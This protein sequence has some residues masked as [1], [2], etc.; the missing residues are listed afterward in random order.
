M[1]LYLRLGSYLLLAV[2]AFG[3]GWKV[4]SWRHDSLQLAI[5]Q[6]AEKAGEAATTGAV[7]AIKKQRPVFTTIQG[8]VERET[9]VETRYADCRHSDTAWGLLGD[10]YTA[11]GGEPFSG[12]TGVPA[13]APAK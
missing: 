11:A 3:V 9:R 5:A 8:K 7:A 10:A 4:N 2:V 13:T 1:S 6:A 12:G